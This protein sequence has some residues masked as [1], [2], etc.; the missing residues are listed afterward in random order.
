MLC[1]C[2]PLQYLK[3]PL[4]TQ[5]CHLAPATSV[6]LNGVQLN[7]L[8]FIH[9]TEQQHFKS[10]GLARGKWPPSSS[11]VLVPPRHFAS[12]RISKG[13]DSWAFPLWRIRLYLAYTLTL[14][15]PWPLNFFLN[16]KSQ[17]IRDLQLLFR[18]PSFDKYPNQ[19][20]K[21]TS[22]TFFFNC[23]S[24]QIKSRISNQWAHINQLS[25]IQF[26]VPSPVTPHP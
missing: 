17:A 16:T 18:R 3:S 7:P 9:S 19:P 15:F 12:Y 22:H 5:R 8:Y 11:N 6:Q 1:L 10:E 24:F 4:T 25:L 23:A 26:F 14:Q 13:H 21:Q 20:F 2:C